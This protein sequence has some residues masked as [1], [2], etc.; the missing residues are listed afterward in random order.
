MDNQRLSY[1]GWNIA[2]AVSDILTSDESWRR[3]VVDFYEAIDLNNVFPR[4][5]H[6]D[7]NEIIPDS[8]LPW[9]R[10]ESR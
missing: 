3:H 6:P 8:I 9:L 1:D 10:H 4:S 7:P 2:L 5:L